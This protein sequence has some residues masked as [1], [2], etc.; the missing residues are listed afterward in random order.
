MLPSFDPHEIERQ[1]IVAM[2]TAGIVPPNESLEMDG[3]IHRYAIEGRD[4][5]REQSGR[6]CIHSDDWP[7]GWFQDWHNGG[8]KQ[9]WKFDKSQLDEPTRTAWQRAIDSPEAQAERES[10]A[11]EREVKAIKER[12]IKR[13]ALADAWTIYQAGRPI[14]TSGDHAYLF[15][16]DIEPR[17][18]LRVGDMASSAGKTLHDVLLIPCCDVASGKFQAL[19]RVF[20][21]R[22]K[23]SGKFPKGWFSGTHGGVFTIDEEASGP[24]IVAEGIATALAICRHFAS[25]DPTVISCMDC[26]N[27]KAQAQAIRLKYEGKKVFVCPDDDDAGRDVADHCMNNAHFNGVIPVDFI[28]PEGN[29]ISGI[30]PLEDSAPEPETKDDIFFFIED[31]KPPSEPYQELTVAEV[32]A[33]YERGEIPGDLDAMKQELRSLAT[34]INVIKDPI[35]NGGPVLNEAC[36]KLVREYERQAALITNKVNNL[37]LEDK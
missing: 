10:R 37:K 19:H 30:S 26:G 7:A 25:Y 15:A 23:E 36:Q 29:T 31:H 16:K 4:R 5:G 8:E 11:R 9:L 24:V 14:E 1:V 20:P 17:G 32:T 18:P 2:E 6:Y 13:T 28:R 27:L 33:Q 3:K 12:E 21:W 22:D 35:L 34:H